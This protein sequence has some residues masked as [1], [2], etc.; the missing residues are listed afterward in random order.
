MENKK[1]GTIVYSV[2]KT[3]EILGISTSLLYAELKRNPKF[4]RKMIGGRILIPAQKL[5]EY[6]NA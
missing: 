2:A 6:F 3:A 4:P 1:I 5:Q